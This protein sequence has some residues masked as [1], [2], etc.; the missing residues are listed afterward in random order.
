MQFVCVA[1]EGADVPLAAIR[2]PAGTFALLSGYFI[3]KRL[4]DP[5]PTAPNPQTTKTSITAVPV[6]VVPTRVFALIYITSS[7]YNLTSGS[8]LSYGCYCCRAVISR[9]YR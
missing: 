3:H 1:F 5:F 9:G 4:A 7:A 8:L 2:L 6:A